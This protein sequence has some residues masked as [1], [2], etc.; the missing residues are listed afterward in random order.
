M[1]V[2][3]EG[4]DRRTPGLELLA[5]EA[6]RRGWGVRWEPT[7]GFALRL[8]VGGRHA[9]AIGAD[10]GLNS[11]AARR[12]AGDKAFA[13]GFLRGDGIACVPG[14]LIEPGHRPD[15]AAFDYPCVVKPNTGD[16]GRGVSVAGGPGDLVAAVEAARRVSA[17]VLVQPARDRPEHRVVVLGGRV[18]AVFSKRPAP[19]AFGA[20]RAAG[21]EWVDRTDDA[22][23]THLETARRAAAALGLTLAGVDLLAERIDE[24]GP[25]GPEVL[26]VNAC[27]GLRALR[28][29]APA[30]AEALARAAA[31]EIE[32]RSARGETG[33][34]GGA[35]G[36]GGSA[37]ISAP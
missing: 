23:E 31:D 26:E 6:A 12:V 17:L 14:A 2:G 8:T 10:L 33:G 36:G 29:L 3:P 37:T 19:G 15:P 25:A 5:S 9:F 1:T 16:R 35:G 27:P 7:T 34:V 20:G 30:R 22:H 21:A 13:A 18:F 28:A 11:A 4:P 24:P 32:R